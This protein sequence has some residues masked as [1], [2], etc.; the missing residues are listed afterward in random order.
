MKKFEFINYFKNF[1]IR[2]IINVYKYRISKKII[3]NKHYYYNRMENM[4]RHMSY[5]KLYQKH[6]SN[7]FFEH[8]YCQKMADMYYKRFMFYKSKIN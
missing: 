5:I 4:C 1:S 6:T 7:T 3:S 8:E 2:N